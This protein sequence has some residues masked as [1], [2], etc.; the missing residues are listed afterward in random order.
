MHVKGLY[1]G[2][3]RFEGLA[4][5]LSRRVRFCVYVGMAS[6]SSRVNVEVMK[7]WDAVSK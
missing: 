6:V 1:G 4:M 2:E 5:A 3:L 7:T